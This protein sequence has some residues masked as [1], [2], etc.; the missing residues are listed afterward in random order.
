[1]G[2]ID[3]AKRVAQEG[4]IYEDRSRINLYQVATRTILASAHHM[5]GEFQEARTLFQAAENLQSAPSSI[6]FSVRGFRFCDFLLDC[7]EAKEVERRARKMWDYAVN[8]RWQAKLQGLGRVDDGISKVLWGAAA[9]KQK[10]RKAAVQLF[11]E[12]IELLREAQRTEY[13]LM[14]LLFNADFFLSINQPRAAKPLLDEVSSEAAHDEMWRL[15]AD[16]KILSARYSLAVGDTKQ[17]KQLFRQAREAV[18]A[19]GYWRREKDLR[20]LVRVLS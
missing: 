14:G 3:E 12:G 4:L 6:L 10:K 2:H 19:M 17:A 20:N 7:G 15:E 8:K 13:L 18:Q 11:G 1:M 16:R 5:A 9:G